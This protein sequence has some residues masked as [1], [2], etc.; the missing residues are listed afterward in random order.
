M[1]F[2]F[3][4]D[5]IQWLVSLVKRQRWSCRPFGLACRQVMPKVQGKEEPPQKRGW[6]YCRRFNKRSGKISRGQKGTQGALWS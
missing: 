5:G 2:G 3:A 6:L 4:E 1:T